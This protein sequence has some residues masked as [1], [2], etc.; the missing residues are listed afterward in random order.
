[1]ADTLA[2]L[3]GFGGPEM[4]FIAILA[5]LMFGAKRLPELARG[6]GRAVRE[7]KRATSGVEEN[8]REVMR[9]DPLAP[10]LRPASRRVSAS[11]GGSGTKAAAAGTAA[12]P[13]AGPTHPTPPKSERAEDELTS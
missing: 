6:V 12:L 4:L 9:E 13:A 10:A 7:F 5:L 11:V 1:M 3:E 2:I 8:L